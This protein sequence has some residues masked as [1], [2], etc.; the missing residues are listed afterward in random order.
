MKSEVP[1][2]TFW[3][4]EEAD[5]QVTGMLQPAFVD[6][7]QL[8]VVATVKTSC[9]S[10]QKLTMRGGIYFWPQVGANKHFGV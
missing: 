6:D 5:V 8:T 7:L 10:W 4:R 2:K 1:R 9:V 3:L